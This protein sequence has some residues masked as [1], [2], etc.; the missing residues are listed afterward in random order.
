ML[1]NDINLMSTV[2]VNNEITCWDINELNSD[3]VLFL[4]DI[5]NYSRVTTTY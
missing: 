2:Y 3:A 4:A 5:C 1:L